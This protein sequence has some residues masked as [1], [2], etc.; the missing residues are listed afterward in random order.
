MDSPTFIERR[1]AAQM[2]CAL[3]KMVHLAE[4]HGLPPSA[5]IDAAQALL[6]AAFYQSQVSVEAH[7]ALATHFVAVHTAA[8]SAM[9][10]DSD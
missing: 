6:D 4:L 9:R 7:A 3:I 1:S 10:A 8:Q 2:R 5:F